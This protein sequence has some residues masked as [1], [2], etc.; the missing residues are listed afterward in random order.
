MLGDDIMSS[1]L[2]FELKDGRKIAGLLE[3]VDYKGD[4]VLKDVIVEVPQNNVSPINEFLEYKFD[5]SKDFE[6]RIKYFYNEVEGKSLA[7]LE[8]R[9]YCVNGLI[10]TRAS[11]ER[12][13]RV[14]RS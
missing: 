5:G 6:A 9:C 4:C 14:I 10:L 13:K 2:I 1:Y 8:K 11:I 7:S 3:C 12:V